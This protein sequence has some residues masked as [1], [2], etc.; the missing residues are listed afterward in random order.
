VKQNISKTWFSQTI[1]TY[2][3]DS[4]KEAAFSYSRT[5]A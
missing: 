4:L 5:V 1:A 3:R 2:A